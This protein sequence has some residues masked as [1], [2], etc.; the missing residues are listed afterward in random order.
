MGSELLGIFKKK[1][2]FYLD[3]GTYLP[4]SQTLKKI[5]IQSE[6]GPP[7]PIIILQTFE[8]SNSLSDKE[9]IAAQHHTVG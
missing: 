7:L 4:E 2:G 6:P 5:L 9:A 1:I 3:I 8:P